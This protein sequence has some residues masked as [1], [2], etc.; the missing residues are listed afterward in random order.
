M[1]GGK[2]FSEILQYLLENHLGK[3]LGLLLG[4]VIGVLIILVG[5]WKS[6]FIVICVAAGYFLGKRFDEDGN[7]DDWWNRLFH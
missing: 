5:F 1:W 3:V 2:S 7:I 6:M 4:L